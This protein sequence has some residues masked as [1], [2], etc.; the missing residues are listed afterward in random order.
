M[1]VMPACVAFFRHAAPESGSRLTIMRT[2]TPSLIIESQIVPNL[3]VSPPAFWMSEPTPAALKAASR[4]GR[5]LFSQRGDVVVSG[6]ITP[7]V[8]LVAPLEPP[9]AGELLSLL[10]QAVSASVHSAPRAARLAHF[11]VA[12]DI[13]LFP[14]RTCLARSHLL[15]ATFTP[16][17]VG[18]NI[19]G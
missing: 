5:S 10:P 17:V 13:S 1:L 12:I 11:D 14:A 4:L 15:V 6:R 9:A 18:H 8:P 7:T 16:Y 2:L 3:A 19:T